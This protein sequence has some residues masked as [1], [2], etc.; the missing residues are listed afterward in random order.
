[1]P[2]W[3]D[4]LVPWKVHLQRVEF[5]AS[6]VNV[7]E[8]SETTEADGYPS[9]SYHHG[10]G[11]EDHFRIVDDGLFFPEMPDPRGN[12]S[13]KELG[14]QNFDEKRQ[15]PCPIR[16][17]VW[18][19][20]FEGFVP[21]QTFQTNF[22]WLSRKTTMSRRNDPASYDDCNDSIDDCIDPVVTMIGGL[23]TCLALVVILR[24]IPLVK[25]QTNRMEDY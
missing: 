24:K 12:A 7:R 6:Y 1:M 23:K 19:L 21:M 25:C 17:N 8:C 13:F 15:C 5:P 4:M 9:G 2:F 18:N 3:G 10:G 14:R 20:L 16:Q 22:I 11:I